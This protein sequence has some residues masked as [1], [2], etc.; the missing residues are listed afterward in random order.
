MSVAAGRPRPRQMRGC[1]FHPAPVRVLLFEPAP[2]GSRSRREGPPSTITSIGQPT[3]ARTRSPRRAI[4]SFDGDRLAE[5]SVPRSLAQ[6]FPVRQAWTPGGHEG[7]PRTHSKDVFREP[8]LGRAQS[9][10]R[11]PQDRHRCRE[12]HRRAVHGPTPRA[13]L[14]NLEG[15]PQEPS[16]RHGRHRLLRRT[17]REVPCPLRLSTARFNRTQPARSSRSSRLAGCITITSD[18]P[19]DERRSHPVS[20]TIYPVPAT[21]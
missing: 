3:V 19:P 10:R 5:A 2:P 21:G 18:E 9:P 6:T 13:V 4:S 8:A 11:T 1:A 15:V 12:V 20:Q 17:D 14:A 7:S 16:G